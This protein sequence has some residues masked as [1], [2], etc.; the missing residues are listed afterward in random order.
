MICRRAA[1]PARPGMRWSASATDST[2]GPHAHRPDDLPGRGRR[3]FRQRDRRDRVA[4]GWLQ[5]PPGRRRPPAQVA[6]RRSRLPPAEGPGGPTVRGMRPGHCPSSRTSE[7]ARP[8]YQAYER[9]FDPELAPRTL[10]VANPAVVRM[11]AVFATLDWLAQDSAGRAR[12]GGCWN[13]QGAARRARTRAPGAS[14][15]AWTASSSIPAPA[16]SSRHTFAGRC[17]VE[18][19]NRSFGTRRGRC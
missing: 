5:R 3:P 2:E 14:S 15:A 11:Q 6:A 9:L 17:N 8:T 1:P 16:N 12:F 4:R 13:A 7:G 10:P 19:V 18:E